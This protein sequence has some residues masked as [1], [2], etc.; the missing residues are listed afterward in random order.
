MAD[1]RPTLLVVDDEVIN[2]DILLEALGKDYA[3]RVDT[4]GAAALNS[5]KD[6]LPDLILLDVM[7][8]GMDGFEVC[9]R[10]KDDPATRDIPIIFITA[11]NEDVDEARG[12]L[13]PEDVH[14]GRADQIIKERQAVLMAAYEIH[15]KRFI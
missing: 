2:I 14:Y 3:V 7:M 12:F 9:R 8:P 6:A 15:P 11:M 4:D 5:I 1:T 13:T 10:L